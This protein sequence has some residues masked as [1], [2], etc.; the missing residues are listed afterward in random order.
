[1]GVQ[2]PLSI[3]P[4]SAPRRSALPA[5]FRPMEPTLGGAPFDDD[6][7]VFEPWWQGARSIAFLE[8]GR[9]RLNTDQLADP[10][11]ALPELGEA[12]PLRDDR[13]ILDGTV[14]VLDERGR[15]DADLLRERLGGGRRE[16]RPAFVAS[17]L[18]QVGDE[19]L[20][21]RPYAQR[22]ERL[23]LRLRGGES[24][25][26]SRG[27]R[28]E[29]RT[30]A[31]AMAEMGMEAISARRLG[32]RYRFGPAGDAWLRLP[33]VDTRRPGERPSLSVIQKLPL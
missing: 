1:M 3:D 27:F 22:R 19:S 28:G 29:G 12:P 5:R 16:G 26:A 23:H 24:W 6:D 21:A 17:D 20:L 9:V 30:V 33:L 25:I 8:G 10:L 15:P 32:A 13:V 31:E 14:L 4:E 2:L 18:L 7:Y 11:E